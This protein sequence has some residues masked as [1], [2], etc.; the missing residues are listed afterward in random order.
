MIV[1][2]AIGLIWIIIE[3]SN[4]LNPTLTGVS[5]TNQ[6]ENFSFANKDTIIESRNKDFQIPIK[7]GLYYGYVNKEMPMMVITKDSTDLVLYVKSTTTDKNYDSLIK[8]WESKISKTDSTYTFSEIQDISSVDQRKET[9][10][11][12]LFKNGNNYIGRILIIQKGLDI[13]IIQGFTK[14]NSWNL[15]GQE[16]EYMISNFEIK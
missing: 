12:E 15:K 16:I 10:I 5:I 1:I 14:N 3:I 13:Y 8:H 6:I 7:Q 9:G 4:Q 2:L 11:V